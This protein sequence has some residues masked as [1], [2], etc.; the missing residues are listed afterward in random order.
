MPKIRVLIVDDSI[1]VRRLVSEVLNA[2]PAIEVAATA[3][4]GAVALAKIPQVSPDLVTLDVEMPG[5]SGLE[6]LAEI[7]KRHPR[8]PVIMFSNHTDR[9]A[10]TTLE[11]LSLGAS[12]YVTK[13]SGTGSRAAALELVR[14]QLVPKIRGLCGLSPDGADSLERPAR[15]T[16]DRRVDVVA[17][18]VSTGGPNALGEI[19][20]RLPADFPV[21]ILIVQHMPELFTRFLAERLS[22]RSSLPVCEAVAGAVVRAGQVWLAP[23]GSHMEVIREGTQVRLAT[24]QKPPESSCRPAVDP[25]FRSVA[26]AYGPHALAVVLTGM[27]TDSLIGCEHIRKAGGRIVVQDEVTST[28][29]GMP[30]A[31]AKAGL[32]DRILPLD[33]IVPD[34]VRRV[35]ASRN[36]TR[37]D[38]ARPRTPARAHG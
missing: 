4:T 7:R 23:G 36:G 10:V 21:P 5:M 31:V 37:E 34:V 19:L 12:D 2:D 26:A 20:P 24:N 17:I 29:W 18:G 33:Q 27:G 6:A 14:R 25:L 16:T 15:R 11:A 8:L 32:A 3:P 30:G 35:R 22:S 13:P 28:V 38:A 9:G 1:I